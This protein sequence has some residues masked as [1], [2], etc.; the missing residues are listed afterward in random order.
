MKLIYILIAC[1]LSGCISVNLPELVSDTAKVTKDAYKSVTANKNEA[2]NAAAGTS[3]AARSISHSY[4]G[5]ESQT[6]ADIKQLCVNEAAS[7]LTQMLGKDLPYRVLENDIVT[8]RNNIVAN[9]KLSV[10]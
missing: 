2:K 1:S 9:C 7:K 10:E 4:V 3:V 5:Q 6:V 8:I